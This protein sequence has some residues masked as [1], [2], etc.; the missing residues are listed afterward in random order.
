V[1]CHFDGEDIFKFIP[2]QATKGHPNQIVPYDILSRPQISLLTLLAGIVKMKQDKD[3]DGVMHLLDGRSGRM[4]VPTSYSSFPLITI[5][6]GTNF[7]I[8]VGRTVWSAEDVRNWFNAVVV[9]AIQNA[10]LKMSPLDK[11]SALACQRSMPDRA[12]LGF[13]SDGI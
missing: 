12:F 2:F 3:L 8:T 11:V 1:S 5:Q 10:Q 13:A 6:D 4:F 7:E 9:P